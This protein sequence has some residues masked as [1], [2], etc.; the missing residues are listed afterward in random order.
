[1]MAYTAYQFLAGLEELCQGVVARLY[2]PPHRHHE[3][4]T[5]GLGLHRHGG[6]GLLCNYNGG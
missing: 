2:R 3:V 5:R 1:M 4:Q 6:T